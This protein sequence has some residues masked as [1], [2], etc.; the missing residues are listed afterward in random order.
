MKFSI[1]YFLT[2][3]SHIAFPIG[4]LEKAFRNTIYLAQNK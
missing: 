1:L 4:T 2:S 3:P